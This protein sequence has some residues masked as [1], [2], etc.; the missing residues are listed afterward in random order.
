[1]VT[2]RPSGVVKSVGRVFDVLEL[3]ERERRALS[4]ITITRSLNY[5]ASSTIGLLKSMVK[6]GY[7]YFDP[8]SFAYIP[9]PRLSFLVKWLEEAPHFDANLTALLEE[10]VAT[11]NETAA[12]VCE[13]DIYA[14]YLRIR[15]TTN[16][17]AYQIAEGQQ[18]PIFQSTNG[19]TLLSTK[20]D[21]EVVQAAERVNK[22]AGKE[23]T[24][25]DV[26]KHLQRIMRFRAAGMGMGY[27]LF[28][29]GL[30]VF[31]WP[32]QTTVGNRPLVMSV[33]GPTFRV[34][35]QEAK[36]IRDVTALLEKYGLRY[37]P[38]R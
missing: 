6:L 31:C 34:K 5:P 27:D 17:I 25:V 29:P 14:Q 7:L 22:R 24:R 8:V 28:A 11:T 1:M 32:L 18:V 38:R 2:Q 21:V 33:G 10:V 23:G 12:I 19:L 16:P 26:Q 9:T 4:A 20:T 36:I 30:A 35:P 37:T 13:N 15:S 3:F